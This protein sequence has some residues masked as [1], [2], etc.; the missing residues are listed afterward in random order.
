M[1]NPEGFYSLCC[2]PV[3]RFTIEAREML[4]LRAFKFLILVLDDLWI[5][6]WHRIFLLLKYNAK[7][8]L[9]A[10]ASD[11]LSKG[12]RSALLIVVVA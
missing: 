5:A 9:G 2:K 10:V 11:A 12:K 4:W 7:K 3:S 8:P 1:F 6:I